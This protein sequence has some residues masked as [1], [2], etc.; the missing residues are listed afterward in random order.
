[1][2]DKTAKGK[3]R[4]QRKEPEQ[5]ALVQLKD[6]SNERMSKLIS[7]YKAVI[8][9]INGGPSPGVGVDEKFNLTAPMPDS[10]PAAA[11]Q[12][13]QEAASLADFVRQIDQAQD[14]YSAGKTEKMQRR[15]QQMQ[16]RMQETQALQEQVQQ[17]QVQAAVEEA[18]HKEASNQLT[19]LWSHLTP[20]SWGEK[21]RGHRLAMLRSLARVD[22]N[23]KD[24][25]NA[26]LGGDPKILNAV[27]LAKQL[28]DDVDVTFFKEFGNQ[29]AS[30]TSV[31][32]NEVKRIG[33]ELQAMQKQLED[34]T[35]M[36]KKDNGQQNEVK[37][38]PTQIPK[39]NKPAAPPATS[40][41]EKGT[42]GTTPPSGDVS[43][44]KTEEK[45]VTSLT[46]AEVKKLVEEALKTQEEAIKRLR[47]DHERMKAPA[48]TTP[49]KGE[50]TGEALKVETP[51]GEIAKDETDPDASLKEQT[52]EP[53]S[54]TPKQETGKE[55]APPEAE[56]PK[57]KRRRRVVQPRQPAAPAPEP[58][59]DPVQILREYAGHIWANATQMY[60]D[61]GLQAAKAQNAP[62]VWADRIYGQ[63]DDVK[64]N[65]QALQQSE[66]KVQWTVNYLKF[67]KAVGDV[68]VSVDSMEAEMK[69]MAN[70]PELQPGSTINDQ[71]LE[72]LARIFVAT[73]QA[74]LRSVARLYNDRIV[75][76]AHNQL[77]RFV[78]R[79]LQHVSG[80]RDKA[81][82][83]RVDEALRT[84][85][86]SLQDMLNILEKKNINFRALITASG[87]FLGS[88]TE[89]YD[90]LSRL[91]SMYN[92][93][94]RIEKSD[95]RI[96]K[97][98][99]PYDLIPNTDINDLKR[100]KDRLAQLN[101]LA[102]RLDEA[103]GVQF[104]LQQKFDVAAEAVNALKDQMGIS[105]EAK[106]D[107]LE[108][109]HRNVPDLVLKYIVEPKE[110][111]K[112]G[113]MSQKIAD[114]AIEDGIKADVVDSFGHVTV[115]LGDEY[116]VD[117]THLQ[118]EFPYHGS[119][120]DFYRDERE[121]KEFLRMKRLF[122]DLAADPMK[123]VRVTLIR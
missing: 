65:I 110:L 13:A 12:A 109:V 40:E 69:E 39:G 85:R 5:E 31:A 66:T 73:H 38:G 112:C 25:E 64:Q 120:R 121:S 84:S 92:S 74:Q 32:E 52:G 107:V 55:E 81:V 87:A 94:M 68:K 100:I 35:K 10:V 80:G 97:D 34:L 76:Y 88:I 111:K 82:R 54:E 46:P 33:K 30:M 114:K 70:N 56:A 7:L 11:Q 15:L 49:D 115:H 17:D 18:L 20:F 2:I 9:G 57:P 63:W 23:L 60:R 36:S 72:S 118:F 26:V 27:N 104:D 53:T 51:K 90:M 22:S 6:Q 62:D 28:W 123:A 105:K 79:M 96:R 102:T 89:V 14:N 91:G 41:T 29:L 19:R 58:P 93:R 108:W 3:Q 116:I 44:E 95:R 45:S 24:V 42:D 59:K 50:P 16:T 37:T 122:D 117:A 61:I 21:G 78:Q 8:K 106:V 113:T 75:R 77:S 119:L 98:R 103:E 67:L 47:D 99:M 43:P 83:L 4:S 48:R 71:R 86:Q 1:M 101:D